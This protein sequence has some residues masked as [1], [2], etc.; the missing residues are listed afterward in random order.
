MS[1]H[2]KEECA[3][4]ASGAEK[5]PGRHGR[6][7][8]M[9]SELIKITREIIFYAFPKT[10]K[11]ETTGKNESSNLSNFRTCFHA[12]NLVMTRR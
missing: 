6:L 5:A 2:R 12:Q 7:G 9:W 1:H 3:S 4:K 8:K 11:K 10:N